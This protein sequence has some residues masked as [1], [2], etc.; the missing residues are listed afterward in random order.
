MEKEIEKGAYS[1]NF[2]RTPL[3]SA[4]Y[5]LEHNILPNLFY[6]D[7]ET[8]IGA[9]IGYE[10]DGKNLLL[11][12]FN[13]ACSS[14]GIENPYSEDDFSFD[15]FKIKDELVVC[16]VNFPEPTE[17]PLSYCSYMVFDL[18]FKRTSFF[19]IECGIGETEENLPFIGGWDKS[20]KHL[21]FGHCTFENMEK[22][23]A[24]MKCLMIH[25]ED[26][27]IMSE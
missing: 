2:E 20:G 11:T 13:E 25:L 17:P 3:H 5:N 1:M 8:F 7:K 9:L 16:V 22:G 26:D 23:E 4:L 15:I 21:N 10:E 14:I 19:C 12:L 18:D 27:D 6:E 24:L